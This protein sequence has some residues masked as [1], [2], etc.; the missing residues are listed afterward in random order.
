MKRSF[1]TLLF[2]VAISAF[3][4]WFW[5]LSQPLAAHPRTITL[6]DMQG[7]V[8]QSGPDQVWHRVSEGEAVTPG[9]TIRTGAGSRV[10]VD[11]Y[12][13]GVTRLAENSSL[14]IKPDTK[15]DE[16]SKTS[17]TRL[18][19]NQGRAWS[20]VRQLLQLQDEYSVTTDQVVAVVRG[21]VFHLEK[22]LDNTSS[23]VV[24]HSVVSGNDGFIADGQ[25]QTFNRSKRRISAPVISTDKDLDPTWMKE[26]EGIDAGSLKLWSSADKKDFPPVR[27]IWVSKLAILSTG[28]RGAIERQDFTQTGE[29]A[30]R[31]A[32]SS[33]H[34]LALAGEKEQALK[35]LEAAKA[36]LANVDLQ[37]VEVQAI[38]KKVLPDAQRLF[39]DVPDSDAGG[40]VKQA[41]LKFLLDTSTD[42]ATLPTYDT[43]KWNQ[44]IDAA[45]DLMKRGEKAQAEKQFT[46]VQTAIESAM[47]N[48]PTGITTEEA[49]A[50]QQR[51]DALLYR[52]KALRK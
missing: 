6:R 46:D 5:N 25:T 29:R 45:L 44:Q 3:G 47:K 23:L 19:L 42:R 51:W 18:Q 16:H 2:L 36:R 24:L 30:V 13:Q 52:V 41:V 38:L 20:R 39:E 22:N 31:E 10:S 33:L 37:S 8:E 27:N 32:L 4:Y 11:V 1:L 34:G 43:L 21:T 48:R 49:M 40:E 35:E 50:L 17:I 15:L 14:L 12:N 26:N 7:E 28:L 9:T